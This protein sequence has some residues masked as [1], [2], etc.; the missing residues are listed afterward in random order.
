MMYTLRKILYYQITCYIYIY[1][2]K[3]LYNNLIYNKDI[4]I[5]LMLYKCNITNTTYCCVIIGC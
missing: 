1:D 4:Y 5:V 2:L 3:T